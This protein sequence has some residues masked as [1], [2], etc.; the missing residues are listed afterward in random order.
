MHERVIF[1]TELN[2][3]ALLRKGAKEQEEWAQSTS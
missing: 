1:L 3:A 2:P